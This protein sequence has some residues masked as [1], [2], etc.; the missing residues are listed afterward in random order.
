MFTKIDYKYITLVEQNVHYGFIPRTLDFAYLLKEDKEFK[1]EFLSSID[2]L[3]NKSQDKSP[4]L[5]EPTWSEVLFYLQEERGWKILFYN[6]LLYDKNKAKNAEL[7][8][9]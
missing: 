7:V 9:I 4:D 6:N 5:K 1:E 8:L 3:Y 2:Y